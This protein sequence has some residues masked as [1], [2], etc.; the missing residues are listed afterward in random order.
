MKVA[1]LSENKKF[2]C[3]LGQKILVSF[4]LERLNSDANV[5]LHVNM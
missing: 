1:A 5:M 3:F 4:C 2:I